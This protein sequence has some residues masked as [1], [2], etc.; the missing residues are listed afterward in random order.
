MCHDR[1][2]RCFSAAL[3]VSAIDTTRSRRWR[4]VKSPG[5]LNATVLPDPFWPRTRSRPRDH[6]SSV[7][8]R[9]TAC[10]GGAPLRAGGASHGAGPRPCRHGTVMTTVSKHDPSPWLN[11]RP[12]ARPM[13]GSDATIV[14]VKTTW[15]GLRN[16]LPNSRTLLTGDTQRSGWHLMRSDLSGRE[17]RC[18]QSLS[19]TVASNRSRADKACST[20]VST[21]GRVEGGGAPRQPSPPQ[22]MRP[23]PPTG[24]ALVSTLQLTG[25]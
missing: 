3:E 17:T 11:R 13:T 24:A 5:F 1:E 6:P 25:F 9:S 8:Q 22:V 10:G 18:L 12:H 16:H 4:S 7:G 20:L 23:A 2:P 15:R 19:I 14:E 21:V